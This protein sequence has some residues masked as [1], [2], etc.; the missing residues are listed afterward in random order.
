MQS[1]KLFAALILTFFFNG[2]FIL[3]QHLTTCSE[4]VKN[5]YTKN[6]KQTQETLF[7]QLDPFGIEYINEQTLFK[8]LAIFDFESI[9]EQE[10]SFNDTDTKKWTGKHDSISVSVSS[11]LVNEPIFV[12]NS[13]FHDLVA[14]FSGAF[15][16]LALH[17]EAKKNLLFDFKTTTKIKLG[18]ILKKLTQ[19]LNRREQADLEVCDNETCTST[20]FLQ[21]QKK[22]LFD[23]QE[24]LEWYCNVLPFFG[25]NSAKYDLKLIKS[26]L[27][28]VL[29]NEWNI[30][31]TVIKKVNQF[32]SFRF[33]D[34]Q[35][36]DIMNFLGGTT[37]PG[38]FWSHTRLQRQKDSS[39]RMVWSPRQN[40]ENRTSPVWC[41]LQ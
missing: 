16:N 10:E 1:C 21:I 17:S 23:L 20:Q 36:L 31:P 24:H 29:V 32:I 27:L 4:R 19:R 38:S 15:E 26:Y 5:V 39:L 35:L 40:A 28:P 25:F 22:Q 41:F 11:N 37:S 14:S 33:G 8:N 18:S 6:L 34:I 9:C 2:T 7:Y 30:G 3:G 12:C 13:N